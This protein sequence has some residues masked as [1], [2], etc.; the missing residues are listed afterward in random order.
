MQK[1]V[2]KRRTI[3]SWERALVCGLSSFFTALVQCNRRLDSLER[4]FVFRTSKRHMLDI[5]LFRVEKGGDP[6]IVLESQ[7]KR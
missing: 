4:Y 3:D 5:N 2:I 1:W 7:R 6:K